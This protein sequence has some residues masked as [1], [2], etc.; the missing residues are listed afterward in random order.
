MYFYEEGQAEEIAILDF[1]CCRVTSPAVDVSYA[2]YTG[3]RP[4]LRAQ[5]LE[6]WLKLY[7][8]QFWQDL[9]VF[10]YVPDEV[11]SYEKFKSDFNHLYGYGFQWALQHAQTL[12]T[13]D[14][15]N[16]LEKIKNST[17]EEVAE[18]SEEL[19]MIPVK[20]AET[21]LIFRDRITG[22]IREALNNAYL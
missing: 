12:L 5:F 4:D 7:H 2:I 22:L 1:Q 19:K 16:D 15:E 6:E 13:Q 11:Y 10:G 14:E 3:T 8:D 18:M 17:A 9:V 20:Q 21:N